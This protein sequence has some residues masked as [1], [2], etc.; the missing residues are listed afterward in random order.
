MSV[1]SVK[2]WKQQTKVTYLNM[3]AQINHAYYFDK[4]LGMLVTGVQRIGK[5]SYSC[6]CL[7]QA[8]GEW[9][10]VKSDIT[11]RDVLICYESDYEAVKPWVVFLPREFLNL[12]FAYSEEKQ[13]AA[14]WDDA[15]F[16]LFALDWYEPFVKAVSRYIQLA[17]TQFGSLIMTT[18]DQ[19]LVSSKV[20]DSLPKMKLCEI[21]E[22]GRETYKVRPRIARIYEKWNWA[23]GKRGGVKKKWTDKFN[24]MLPDSFYDW[25]LP[26]RQA[27]LIDGKNI[28]KK[29]VSRL[30]TKLGLTKGKEDA[31]YMEEVYKVVGDE[32]RLK[33]VAEVLA[34]LESQQ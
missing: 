16:W 27:Y 3:A 31:D 17:G 32:G 26:K 8:C 18:P 1:T 7:A 14:I 13:R 25:Y 15:G 23:D 20:L 28:L 4:F 22:F 10:R 2:S 33:E 6:K 9:G 21:S 5:S 12:I 34:N 24:A 11:D 19:K 29:E 30:D